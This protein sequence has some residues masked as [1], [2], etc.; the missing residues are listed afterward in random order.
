[1]EISA[2]VSADESLPLLKSVQ[3]QGFTTLFINYNGLHRQSTRP[4]LSAQSSDKGGV[5]ICKHAYG[6]LI[7]ENSSNQNHMPFGILYISTLG[8]WSISCGQYLDP[9]LGK[10]CP[11]YGPHLI[12]QGGSECTDYRLLEKYASQTPS[13]KWWP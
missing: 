13:A 12:D 5:H 11:I 10:F 8:V 9:T 1:M 6:D 7:W 2:Y 4:S 3:R